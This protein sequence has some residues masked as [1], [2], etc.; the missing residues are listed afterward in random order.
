MQQHQPE[1]PGED[2]A[3]QGRKAEPQ[4]RRVRPELGGVCC[5]LRGR[6]GAAA[7]S[8]LSRLQC[9]RD[10]LFRYPLPRRAGLA[11]CPFLTLSEW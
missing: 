5:R 7:V 4:H 8:G 3:Q 6:A 10:L 1:S 11:V 2:P 9:G